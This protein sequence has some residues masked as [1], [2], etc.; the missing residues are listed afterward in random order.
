MK[1]IEGKL[2]VL[3]IKRGNE[4][5]TVPHLHES[6]RAHDELLL[7]GADEDIARFVGHNPTA[8]GDTKKS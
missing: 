6:I 7:V 3:L 8:N 1:D 2:N 5:I 4:L